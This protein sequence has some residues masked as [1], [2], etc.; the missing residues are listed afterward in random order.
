MLFFYMNKLFKLTLLITISFMN[1][2]CQLLNND[3]YN[4]IIDY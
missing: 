1:Y 4:E 2:S 3:Y